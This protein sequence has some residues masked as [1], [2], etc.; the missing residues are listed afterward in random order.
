MGYRILSLDGGG[1]WAL[2]QVKAL[3]KIYGVTTSGHTVLRDFDLVVANSGGSIVAASLACNFTLQEILNHFNDAAWR[4]QIFVSSPFLGYLPKSWPIPKYSALAKLQGLQNVLQNESNFGATPLDKLPAMW[5]GKPHMVITSFDYDRQRAVI[6]R[7]N[8]QSPARSSAP[9]IPATLAQAVH[10][11]SNAPIKYFNQPAAFANHR[12][13]DGAMAGLNNPTLTG[14]TE[15]LA[16]N[17][18]AIKSQIKV[19]S[20]G[21]GSVF[22]PITGTPTSFLQPKINQGYLTDIGQ[23]AGCILDDPPD[24]ATFI[25]YTY[26]DGNFSGAFPIESNTVVRLNPLIQPV[27]ESDSNWHVPGDHLPQPPLTLDEFNVLVNL[28][29][30]PNPQQVALIGRF[31]DAWLDDIVPNQPIRANSDTLACEIGHPIFSLAK[32]VW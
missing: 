14:I 5:G 4:N 22:L 31:C 11:S 32:A 3:I 6:F 13:W 10:A 21:T 8:L 17:G 29:L 25:A 20:I 27:L 1:T 7:S 19:R 15:A 12:F 9:P 18:Q 26:L 16:C 24:E 2:I 30:D 23:A 28:G